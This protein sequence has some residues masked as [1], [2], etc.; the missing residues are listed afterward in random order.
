MKWNSIDGPG[1]SLTAALAHAGL[2]KKKQLQQQKLQLAAA[3]AKVLSRIGVCCWSCWSFQKSWLDFASFS[4]NKVVL[5]LS[6]QN[7][8]I[9]F[10]LLCH[11]QGSKLMIWH[12]LGQGPANFF[13]K[14]RFRRKLRKIMNNHAKSLNLGKKVETKSKNLSRKTYLSIFRLTY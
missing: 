3:I 8:Q 6:L 14:P 1:G 12:A 10:E 9:L 5:S 11:V 4:V 7:F 13:K 2:N